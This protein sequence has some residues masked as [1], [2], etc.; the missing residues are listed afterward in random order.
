MIY[1]PDGAALPPTMVQ[2]ENGPKATIPPPTVS[3]TGGDFQMTPPILSAPPVA[4]TPKSPNTDSARGGA[5]AAPVA[6]PSSLE[7]ANV[8]MVNSVA[9]P[10]SGVTGNPMLTP[11][12]SY[13]AAPAPTAPTTPPGTTA[14][15]GSEVPYAV[16]TG[17]SQ[18]TNDLMSQITQLMQQRLSSG[19]G[20][21]IAPGSGSTALSG[22]LESEAMR[23]LDQPTVYD[24]DLYKNATAMMKRG[25]SENYAGAQESLNAELADRGI[26]YSTIAGGRNVDLATRKA[27]A[28]SDV[29]V[30]TLRERAQ[31]MASGRSAA[32]NNARGISGDQ[33][34]MQR[35]ARDEAR[36][37]RGYGDDRLSSILNSARGVL[38]DRVGIEAGQR[39][40]QRGERSYVD[41]LRE[42][43]RN[44]G[45][46]LG[47]IDQG[48][49]DQNDSEY[50]QLLKTIYGYGTDTSGSNLLD[51]AGSSYGDAASGYARD[52]SGNEDDLALLAQ[53]IMRQRS[54]GGTGARP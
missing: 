39:Q 24:D 35:G 3:V 50:A 13:P 54:G 40:E 38:G 44:Q 19:G 16:G 37:E 15:T 36:Y 2:D 34:D 20:P 23:Q 52:A 51:R 28:L 4:P 49:N 17:G 48:Y 14:I 21:A 5:P 6:P 42:L 26:N 9:A 8:P 53:M 25:I 33:Y 29:D 7:F 18:Q 43:A 1:K 11:P 27:Q 10:P 47:Q 12:P 45:L 31:A 46:Q 32:F 41:N 30:N 22:R